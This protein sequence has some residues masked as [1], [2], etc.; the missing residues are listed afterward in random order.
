MAL[1]DYLKFNFYD[2][3]LRALLPDWDE[4]RFYDELCGLF[5]PFE[6]DIVSNLNKELHNALDL[7][8]ESRKN[9][10]FFYGLS[11]CGKTTF[12][13]NF[14]RENTDKY[15]MVNINLIEDPGPT[16]E[17]SKRHVK[18]EKLLST[19]LQKNIRRERL[20]TAPHFLQYLR[21]LHDNRNNEDSEW[22][23]LMEE[24]TQDGEVAFKKFV[25]SSQIETPSLNS[26]FR[27]LKIDDLLFIYLLS[28]IFNI[29]DDN[30]RTCVFLFDNLDELSQVYIAKNLINFLY[31]IFSRV[32]NFCEKV[33]KYSWMKKVRFLM[34]FR[35]VHYCMFAPQLK[36]RNEILSQSIEI[37]FP[38]H[39]LL[40]KILSRRLEIAGR[41]PEIG[42]NKIDKQR[43]Q[44]VELVS[45]F[46]CDD[47]NTKKTIA[48]LFNFD[49]RMIINMITGISEYD[50]I[51]ISK[52]RY[53]S[54]MNN[55][56]VGARGI[57]LLAILKYLNKKTQSFKDIIIGNT[58]KECNI[59]R[60]VLTLLCN[61][62]KSDRIIS[63]DEILDEE[64]YERIYQPIFIEN[65]IRLLRE[66][67]VYNSED[68]VE[69]FRDLFRIS[70]N[71]FELF[72]MLEVLEAIDNDGEIIIEES[73][74]K[75]ISLIGHDFSDER[76]EK[77]LKA[78]THT[79]KLKINPS[80]VI[81]VNQILIH[82]EYYNFY[83]HS[84]NPMK[85]KYEIKPLFQS[86]NLVNGKF[87]FEEQLTSVFNF[88]VET[89]KNMDKFFCEKICRKKEENI[90][91]C[92]AKYIDCKKSVQ[93]FINEGYC[94]SNAL[95]LSRVVRSHINY[96]DSFREFLW[97]DE[98]F[99]N[100][101]NN[102][103]I[104]FTTEFQM[105]IDVQEHINV[106]SPKQKIQ[107]DI[108]NVI[109]QYIDFFKTKKVKDYTMKNLVDK[110]VIQYEDAI[111]NNL[112]GKWSGIYTSDNKTR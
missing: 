9:L 35:E 72:I 27:D 76:L 23:I 60:M 107:S 41:D 87:E 40:P 20:L 14:F 77:R 3:K 64:D 53:A 71:S 49:N 105:M 65:T 78:K 84:M 43:Q 34:A 62:S 68:L 66:F 63:K 79:L 101:L 6:K 36:E 30:E 2:N 1:S 25:T 50:F 89:S 11:G 81:Y 106:L 22:E 93:K 80:S 103:E 61:L 52:I 15:N 24:F 7:F 18:D 13:R 69:L 33:L 42:W 5:V 56:L 92:E 109:S 48:P 37:S 38:T 82:Y 104:Q 75:V 83:I 32:Q 86:I 54:I 55:S 112:D 91:S 74:D 26:L 94:A 12:I 45:I 19:I 31:D 67:N 100:K 90:N 10:I 39:D 99:N 4:Q 96:I 51:D 21:K 111:K 98:E 95:Y 16:T 58:Q 108:L 46:S 17:Q 97:K 28:N 47:T 70:D 88:I 73:I 8:S 110:I 102:K 59:F 57:I 85:N 29:K 44:T